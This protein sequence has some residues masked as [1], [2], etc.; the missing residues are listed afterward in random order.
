MQRIPVQLITG[1]LGAGKTTFL[2]H[3][4]RERSDERLFVIENEVGKINVDCELVMNGEEDVAGLTAGCLCCSLHD[5]LLDVLEEVSYRRAEYDRLVIETTGVADPTSI[6]Q[7][8]LGNR[9]VERV[10]DLQQVICLADAAYVEENIADT[11]EARRQLVSADVVLL[12]KCDQVEPS[13]VDQVVQNLSGIHP[14]ATIFRGQHG[15]FP[16]DRIFAVKPFHDEQTTQIAPD[17]PK[18]AH[19]HNDI[20]TFTLSFDRPFH[21]ESLARELI[22]IAKLY[23]HQ[24]YRIKGIIAVNSTPTRVVIQSVRDSFVLTDGPPWESESQRISHIVFI[25]KDVKREVIEKILNRHLIKQE[26][27]QAKS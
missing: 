6:I 19:R 12:N 2:N 3:L 4:I 27:S 25:G 11:D 1:F 17:V 26:A 14:T 7:T 5:K 21:L 22:K 23:R 15:I 13:V 16:V 8:F 18:G 9:M 20:T 24:V 10:F